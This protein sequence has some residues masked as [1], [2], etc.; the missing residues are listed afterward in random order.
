MLGSSLQH[1]EFD[2]SEL[3]STR[4][5][6]VPLFGRNR[7]YIVMPEI[8]LVLIGDD[9][10]AEAIAT[11][12]ESSYGEFLLI[13]EWASSHPD[14]EMSLSFQRIVSILESVGAIFGGQNGMPSK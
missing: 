7:A 4:V 10:E 14:N 8:P 6:I 3:L 1:R 5:Q 12:A 13:K 2:H 11:L 9:W